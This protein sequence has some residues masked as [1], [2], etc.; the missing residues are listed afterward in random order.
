[1]DG[2]KVVS[3]SEVGSKAF[4]SPDWHVISTGDF[5]GDGKAD[6]LWQ[7]KDGTPGI[8]QMDG[9]TILSHE[10]I[11][12]PPPSPSAWH[13][14]DAGDFDGNGKADILWQ[15]A[16]GAPGIWL[17]DG[18]NVVGNAEI[19][20]KAQWSP[21]WHVISAGDFDGNG[22]ADILWQ[23][24]DGTAAVWL[25]DGLNVVKTAAVGANPGTAWNV[26]DAG[27]FNADGK[28]DILWQ[29]DNGMAAI[30]LM[31]GTNVLATAGVGGNPGPTWNAVRAGDVNGDGK[32]D[33][34][35]QNDN[36][37]AG[38]WLMDGFNVLAAATVGDNPGPQWH[39]APHSDFLM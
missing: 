35:W 31:D 21:A 39:L 1:M 4:W 20:T 2:L 30:W 28:A 18:F 9:S 38:I 13:A 37:A 14:I 10:T 33:I 24:N 25:M 3:H 11:G 7:N 36:G 32:S 16:D 8:W 27:D 19:G 23:H 22:K 5:N 29:H 34:L 15:R 26:I 17:M 12:L 6:I